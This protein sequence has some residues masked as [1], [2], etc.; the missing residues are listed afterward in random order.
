VVSA[1]REVASGH[2]RRFGDAHAEVLALDG[3]GERARGATLYVSLEP[4]AHHGH[5]PP[6]VDRI[7]AAGIARVVAPA[8][9]PDARV[10]GRGIARLRERGIR[11][12]VGGEATAAV[13]EN[14]G[15]YR[16]R[17]G[18]GP[19]VT[20]KI[21]A[22]ADGM[23]A[24]ARGQR[25]DVTGA[26]ARREVHGL[27]ALHDAVVV[28]VETALIDRPRLDCRLLEGG[29]DRE[30]MPVVIDTHLRTEA[31][32]AWS[33][34]G[35][36]FVV[37]TGPHVDARSK[38]AEAAWWIAG[39][40]APGWMCARWSPVSPELDANAFWWKADRGC[41]GVFC[42]RAR[43]TPCG[44]TGRRRGSAPGCRGSMTLRTR[45]TRRGRD[46]WSTKRR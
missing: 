46:D 15:Y 35:R 13:L 26:A 32:N 20:L 2:H 7:L 1:G 40:R 19:T 18:L 29:V 6:C 41:S 12:D 42:A 16:Q 9:D 23:A 5:T 44:G 8:P 22:S 21:A 4:C 17:L 43:G 31:D 3:A 10:N 38:R 36:P 11:V 14:L 27:R 30:P 45:T 25:D 39:S 33:R 24:R 28:G 34:A 37:V